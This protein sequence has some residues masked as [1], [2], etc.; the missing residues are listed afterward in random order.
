MRTPRFAVLG[1][2]GRESA[3]TNPDALTI[4]FRRFMYISYRCRTDLFG[5]VS[6]GHSTLNRQFL[7]QLCKN[8]KNLPYRPIATL[9]SAR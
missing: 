3:R 9:S 6:Y 2:P 7:R 5:E 1:Q 4:A 8:W